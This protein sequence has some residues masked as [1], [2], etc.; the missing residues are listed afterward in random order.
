MTLN[1]EIGDAG[2]DRSARSSTLG[3]DL[4]SERLLN[5]GSGC[6]I[7][8]PQRLHPMRH[9]SEG[10]PDDLRGAESRRITITTSGHTVD[11][12]WGNTE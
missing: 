4:K 12:S 2:S 3:Q 9:Q 11:H 1:W 6:E 10:C 5:A 8:R 7:T